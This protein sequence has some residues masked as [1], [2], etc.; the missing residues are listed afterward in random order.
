MSSYKLQVSSVKCQVTNDKCQVWSCKGQVSSVKFK[1]SNVMCQVSSVKCQVSSVG[2]L[3]GLQSI[4]SSV[5]C[6]LRPNCFLVATYLSRESGQG[7][8]K[9]TGHASS[10]SPPSEAAWRGQTP[11]QQLWNE[12]GAGS[13]ELWEIMWCIGS[14][15]G[16]RAGMGCTWLLGSWPAVLYWWCPC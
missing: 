9:L 7:C 6:G 4:S 12:P 1:V 14:G 3:Q 2:H 16:H 8:A 13:W 10:C 15:G 5:N 11:L